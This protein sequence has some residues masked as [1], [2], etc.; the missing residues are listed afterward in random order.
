VGRTVEEGRQVVESKLPAVVTVSKD[1]GEP[2]YPSFMGIRKASRAEIPVW[3]LADLGIDA[4]TSVI[5]WP[6]IE[7]PPVR[8]ILTEIVSGDSPQEIANK[9]ADKIMEEKVL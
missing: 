4:P 2:R 1:I 9:L 6:E 3:G 7:N 5:H 8:E